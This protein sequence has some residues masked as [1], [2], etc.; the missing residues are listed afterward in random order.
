MLNPVSEPNPA[1][2]IPSFALWSLAFRP[3]YLGAAVFS[4]LS[5]TLWVMEFSGLVQGFFPL[6]PLLHAHEMLFGYT[7]AVLVGFLLTA[8]RV[9]TGQNTVSGKP[10]AAMFCLWLA[11]RLLI[12]T[13]YLWLSLLCNALFALSAAAALAIPLLR[14]GNTRNLFFVLALCLFGL[15]SVVV[16]GTLMGLWSLPAWLFIKIQL[17]VLLIIMV[18]MAGRVIPMFS[19]NGIPGL[20]AV[21]HSLIDTLASLSVVLLL[22]AGVAGLPPFPLSLLALTATVIHSCRLILWRSWKTSSTPL[23]WVLHLAYAWIVLHLF[24]ISLAAAGYV[25][26]SVATHALTAG[27][28]STL[29]LG[30]MVRTARGHLGMPLKASNSDTALFL[31]IIGA[32]VVRVI[33][34]LIMPSSYMLALELSSLLWLSSYA[35]YVIQY[36]PKLCRPRLDGLVG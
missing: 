30:M 31:L 1:Q 4:A 12:L 17:D 28:L 11:A 15:F 24:F 13:P 23:V 10:L 6:N 2:V 8:A 3:F 7:L 5:V 19:N 35:L 16:H 27:A 9:W 25:D 34:P 29:T 20:G 18:V 26:S 33:L 36:G 21:K 22:V 32:G 14:T